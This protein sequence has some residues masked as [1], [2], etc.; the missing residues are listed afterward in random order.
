MK[1]LFLG[2][3]VG[4][5][6]RKAVHYMLPGLV[7]EGAVDL[8]IANVE[9]AS[10]G[11]GVTH[12]TVQELKNSG[13]QVM[14]SGN[15][16]WKKPGTEKLLAREPYLIRP[17]NY[18]TGV[19]GNGGVIWETNWGD[20]VG[21]INLAGRIFME[22]LDCPFRTAEKYVHDFSE[23]GIS[24]I[25]LDFHAE[26]TSEKAALGCFLD[27]KVSAVL[28][29]HTHIQTADNRILPKGSGYITDVGMTGAEDSVIGVK[30]D[31]AL[32]KFLT[33]MP[34]RLEPSSKNLMINGVLLDVCGKTGNCRSIKRIKKNLDKK[35]L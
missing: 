19:P 1:I 23:A 4:R 27:G 18:P 11:V 12:D 17:A 30:P 6:G 2:D 29:T 24:M 7:D 10:K 3:V 22:P 31:P 32:R 9:N 34:Q 16:I 21:I 5:G 26:A 25:L 15:H 13:I 14:T 8:V 20:K 35:S 33:C 28:G